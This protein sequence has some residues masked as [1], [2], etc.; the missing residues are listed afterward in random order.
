MWESGEGTGMYRK[1][2]S[3]LSA[4]QVRVFFCGRA[5]E[6]PSSD[7]QQNGMNFVSKQVQLFLCCVERG[8]WPDGDVQQNTC[9]I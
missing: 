4:I 7:A 3:M 6:G 8:E 1:T 9:S 5:G 2:E